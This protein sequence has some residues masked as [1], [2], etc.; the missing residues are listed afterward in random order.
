MSKTATVFSTGTH[1]K[2]SDILGIDDDLSTVVDSKNDTYY[3]HDIEG[4]PCK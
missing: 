4:C 1:V 2:G 3:R